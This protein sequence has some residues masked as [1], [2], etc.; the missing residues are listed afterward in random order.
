MSLRRE[1]SWFVIAC[2]AL[3]AGPVRAAFSANCA[4]TSTGLVPLTDL[5]VGSYQGVQGGLYA[6]GS[7]QRPAAHEAAGLAIAN[8]IVPLDTLGHPSANGRVVIV[9]I[10]MSNCTQE[11]ST[12]IPKANADPSRSPDVRAIDC[13]QGG[14]TAS[15]IRNPNA[16]FWNVVAQRL[17][18][19]GSSPL[20]PQI[21]WLKEANAQPNGNFQTTAGQL[22]DDL[23]EVVRV[24]H[25][26]LPSVR[27]CYV[28]SRIYAG[29]ASSTLNPEPYAYESGFAVKWLIDEQISG[30]DSLNFD[31]QQGAVGAPWLSWG[32]YLWADGLTPRS[33][34]LTW[35][36]NEFVDSDGTHPSTIGRNVVADSLLSFFH[37]DAT[38]IPWYLAGT[39]GV[40]APRAGR[41]FTVTP[42]PSFGPFDVA[43]ATASGEP[44]RLDLLDLSGRRI[45]T[46]DRGIGTGAPISR[47]WDSR[48]AGE[49]AGIYW[50]RLTR[51]AETRALRVSLL[52]GR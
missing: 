50:V 21:V 51:G 5:G 30:V 44:W 31:P 15:I 16:A 40:G 52:E 8:S 33:D 20:Q 35:A 7:N 14:Q 3:I 46:I 37:H 34:G 19:A 49:R 4:G 29:Y 24:I 13:A 2:L 28:T 26:Q 32:P 23:A 9:S 25:N 42:N 41:A 45:G 17:R 36:C 10:G 27:L 11:F 43:F 6:A 12:F 39:T 48:L 22:R 1:R 18:A 38:T 47:R